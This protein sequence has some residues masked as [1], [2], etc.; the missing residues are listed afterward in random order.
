MLSF[1]PVGLA[2][3]ILYLA[4]AVFL[5]FK[6]SMPIKRQIM[7]FLLFLCAMGIIAVT[8]FPLPVDPRVIATMQGGGDVNNLIPFKT[9]LFMLTDRNREYSFLNIGGNVLLFAPLGFLAPLLFKKLNRFPTVLLFGFSASLIV[10]LSQFIISCILGFTYRS[11]DVDDILLNAVGTILG[12][13]VLRALQSLVRLRPGL[14]S[15]KAYAVT[16]TCVLALA[17]L[18]G[19]GY[20]Y[21]THRTPVKAQECYAP[22]VLPLK[23]IPLAKG[24]VLI[25]QTDPSVFSQTGYV[26]WYMQKD[27]L[28]GWRMSARSVEAQGQKS[29]SM[30]VDGRVFV[31]GTGAASGSASSAYLYHGKEYTY[32]PDGR[33]FWY[34]FL[35]FS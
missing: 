34:L 28:L 33:G 12:F 7:S 17:L 23:T 16:G 9:I 24:V 14:R 5:G 2:A 11:F 27:A 18:S 26:A 21:Y 3:A 32:Q 29:A 6:R 4:A 1:Y 19:W 22:D 25:T 15:P 20:R 13:G 31:W 10:E 8:L 35:P 30:M